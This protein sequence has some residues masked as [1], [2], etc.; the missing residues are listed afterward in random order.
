MA[1]P[2]EFEVEIAVAKAASV[3]REHGYEG[4][5]AQMLVDAMGIGRQ[6]LYDTFGDKWGVYRAAL[7]HYCHNECSAHRDTL[8]HAERAID[9][10][11]AMF[12]RVVERSSEGCLGLGSIVE[13]GCRHSELTEIRDRSGRFLMQVVSDAVSRAQAEGDLSGELN[14]DH[15]SGFLISAI[16]SIRVAARGGAPSSQLK[17]IADFTIRGLR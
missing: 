6:S 17:A 5:S 3:F 4:T 13:F 10:I 7:T 15:A 1:R 11:R 12:A 8:H 16:A 9:G 2:K 14:R